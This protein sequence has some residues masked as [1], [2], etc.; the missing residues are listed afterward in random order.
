M[1]E[2]P[3]AKLLKIS[4][5]FSYFLLTGFNNYAGFI[6]DQLKYNSVKNAYEEK[7]EII[8]AKLTGLS[9]EVNQLEVLIK[10]YMYEMEFKVFVRNK[11][12]DEW[13]EYETFEFCSLSGYL[14]PKVREYDF[15]VPE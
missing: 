3:F 15:Q 12:A 4:A 2:N 1:T 11:S 7:Y 13:L 9:I 10:A 14:G 8:Q 5:L 6:D